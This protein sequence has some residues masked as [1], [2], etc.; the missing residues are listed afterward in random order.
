MT[1]DREVVRETC[2]GGGFRHQPCAPGVD[3]ERLPARLVHGPVE[4]FDAAGLEAH[5]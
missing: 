3:L 5:V 1:R 2:A 4:E